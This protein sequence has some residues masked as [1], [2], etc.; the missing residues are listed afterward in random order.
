MAV[1]VL[2]PV[3]SKFDAVGDSEAVGVPKVPLAEPLVGTAIPVEACCSVLV[4]VVWEVPGERSDVEE[5][6]DVEVLAET[7]GV[8]DEALTVSTVPELEDSMATEEVRAVAE[9]IAASAADEAAAMTAF[10]P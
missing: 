3:E 2:T 10:M 1:A 4:T 7:D 5:F 6:D 8:G 9:D